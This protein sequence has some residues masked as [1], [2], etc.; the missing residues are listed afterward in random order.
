MPLPSIYLDNNTTSKP[1]EAAISKMIPFFSHLWGV[2]S[3]PHHKGQEL[4]PAIKEAYKHIYEFI[5]AKEEDNFI[6]TS[7]GAEAI[8]QVIHSTYLNATIPTG[9]N[10]FLVSALSEAP[11]IMAIENL[12]QVGCLGK[13]IDVNSEG[14]ITLEALEDA[15]TPRTALLSLP[16][17]EGLTGAIQPLNE[18]RDLCQRRGILLHLDATH[19]LGKLFYELEEI[20]PDFLTFNGDHL[21][22]PKGTGGLYIPQGRKCSPLIAGGLEQGGLRAGHLNV[23]YL[24]ALAQSLKESME[25]QDYVC[26]EIARLRGKLETLIS[27]AIPEAIIVLK[28]SE[29]LPHCSTLIFPK[30]YNEALLYNLNKKGIYACIGGG[31]FQQLSLILKAIG[32]DSINA[33]NAISFSLSR[34]TT[35]QEID[36]AA[37]IIIEEVKVLSHISNK[38]FDNS[39]GVA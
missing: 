24:I 10:H 25:A 32:F 39:A 28:D 13:T 34:Y 19:V 8:N 6:L 4:A 18:I 20:K 21:H 37:A 31:S 38:I 15:I 2:S 30:V 35:E 17:G 1:S 22:A 3:A 5:G 36:Q 27:K 23:P 26:T 7:S 29:R 9:K 12:E 16:W 11:A 14:I 33:H